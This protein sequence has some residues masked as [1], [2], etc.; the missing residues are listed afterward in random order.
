[1]KKCPN[2]LMKES[3]VGISLDIDGTHGVEGV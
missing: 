2:K 3:G 1:M